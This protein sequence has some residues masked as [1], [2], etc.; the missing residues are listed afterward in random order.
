M[1][2]IPP[3]PGNNASLTLL[4]RARLGDQ[5][6]WQVLFEDCYPKIV[7]VVR[8]RLSRP[9]RRLCDSTDIA[10][11]V[12]KSL[13]AKFDHFDFS[14][15]DGLRAF[16]IRAA[17]QKVV[18]GYRRGYAQKRTMDRDQALATGGPGGYDP[19]DSSP[20]PSQMAVASEAFELLL[21]GQSGV[22]RTILELKVQGHSNSEVAKA[23]GWHLRR[24][25]RFLVKLRGTCRL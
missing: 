18:D 1:P 7:R 11:E 6:A 23:T 20:T 13:A 19:A 22:D 2:L 12:M 15:I 25:E 8:K 3:S 9:M 4:D 10:N 14:S 24:V 16:L 21:D 5:A 17:E